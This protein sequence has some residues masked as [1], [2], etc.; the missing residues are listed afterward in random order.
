MD[1][2]IITPIRHSPILYKSFFH[3]LPYTSNVGAVMNVDFEHDTILVTI[4]IPASDLTHKTKRI[5]ISDSNGIPVLEEDV[6]LIKTK[7]KVGVRGV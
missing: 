4:Q 1:Q 3:K 5:V 6:P 7:F 2:N